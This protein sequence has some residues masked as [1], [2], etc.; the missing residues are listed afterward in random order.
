MSVWFLISM[1]KK[2]ND[3]ADIAWGLGFVLLSWTSFFLSGEQSIRALAV[4]ILISVWGVRLATHIFSRNRNKSEDYR[5]LE[6]RKEWGRYFYIRSFLQVYMLQGLLLFLIVFP[7]LLTNYSFS[8]LLTPMDYVAFSIW[9]LGF[10]FES[11]GDKQ[12]ADFIKDPS[13]TGKIMQ[14]GL[15][16]YTRHPNYF[17]EVTQWWGIWLFSVAASQS[18]IGIIGPAT[19][20]VLILFVSGIPLLEK[21]YIGNTD[22]E[23]YKK[24]T[25]MFF[26]MFPK[27][28]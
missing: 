23:E 28:S 2:R 5:Y 3:V 12:L 10:L 15:W 17:G 6:W 7:A 4:N 20:T 25:S 13:N 16:K 14:S 11:I 9:L 26:P 27:R 1:I 21:K 24:R 22:F 19:I 8:S 18:Y